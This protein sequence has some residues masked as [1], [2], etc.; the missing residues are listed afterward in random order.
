MFVGKKFRKYSTVPRTFTYVPMKNN[1]KEHLIL[2][3][4]FVSTFEYI[5][6]DDS[7]NDNNPRFLPK[8]IESMI[9]E[10]IF[11]FILNLYESMTSYYNSDTKED[12][13]EL[14]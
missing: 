9:V 13:I 3:G 1:L 6:L 14:I 7:E 10:M 12:S 5:V 4:V 2:I 11:K 8:H